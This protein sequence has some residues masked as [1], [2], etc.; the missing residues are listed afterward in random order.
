MS[1]DTQNTP[2]NAADWGNYWEGRAAG[3]AGAALVGVGV[4]SDAELDAFWIKALSERDKASR[5]LDLATGAGTVLRT[6]KAQGFEDLTGVD[7]SEAA[8]AALSREVEGVRSVVASVDALPLEDQSFDV[9]TSQFG[10]EY[11]GAMKAAGE[12]ARVVAPG[13]VFVA[14][15]H[16]SDG[17]IAQEV[18]GKRDAAQAI[19]E[20]GFIERAKAVFAASDAEFAEAAQAFGPAQAQVLGQA[21]AGDRMA[22]HLYAGTQQLHERAGAYALED[23][24]GWLEGMGGEIRA[25]VGR[26][27]SM[28]EA[29][30]N[31]T[32]VTEMVGVLEA[33]GLSVKSPEAMELGGKA[34]AWVVKA[35]RNTA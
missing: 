12:A 22:A 11:A 17:A 35:A 20:S 19:L 24:L 26:M 23:R 33:Q 10:L 3:K 34:A 13:G 4:E 6:A 29:A 18:Q 28:L 2:Q 31:E 5:V 25:F 7:I 32:Q 21:K 9:V 15:C 30:L 14:V 8:L 27:E 16:L 1:Q